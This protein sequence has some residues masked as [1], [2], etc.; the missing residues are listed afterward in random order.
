[1]LEQ[2]SVVLDGT[3][4][5]K[6]D[7]KETKEAKPKVGKAELSKDV[8]KTKVEDLDVTDKIKKVLADN[9][10]KT[11]ASLTKKTEANLA[12]FDGIAEKGIKDIKK[13]LKKIGL[14][15]KK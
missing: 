6:K 1:M 8:S 15:L 11:V 10:V 12:K 4:E 9:K 13:A 7:K 5:E 14:E 3:K 2:F